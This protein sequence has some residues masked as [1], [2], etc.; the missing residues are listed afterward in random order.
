MNAAK[1]AS[2]NARKLNQEDVIVG[3]D[4]VD[5]HGQIECPPKNSELWNMHPR[6]YMAVKLRKKC[7]CPYCGAVYVYKD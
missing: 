1:K 2:T 6:V 3:P 5:Q 7:S 4:D